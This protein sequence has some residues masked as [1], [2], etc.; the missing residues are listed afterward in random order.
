MPPTTVAEPIALELRRR[1]TKDFIYLYAQI[2]TALCYLV[3]AACLW[4]VRGWKV[5]EMEALEEKSRR[6]KGGSKRE[7]GRVEATVDPEASREGWE[8]RG[9][10]RR[11]RKRTV[12]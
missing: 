9:L 1:N 4:V 6:E 12:V 10:V 2:F 8:V 5:G 3:G 11:M 7:M